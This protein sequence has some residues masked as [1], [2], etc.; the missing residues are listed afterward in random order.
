MKPLN[1]K[2]DG[3]MAANNW[4]MQFLSNIIDI[5]VER[6]T[7]LETTALGAA[8]LAGIA[9]G[10]FSSVEDTESLWSLDRRFHSEMGPSYRRN[11]SDGWHEAVVK[12]RFSMK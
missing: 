8:I 4:L 6:P 5:T 2:V 7:Q 11:L 3:G 9:D 1:L 12:T 10:K